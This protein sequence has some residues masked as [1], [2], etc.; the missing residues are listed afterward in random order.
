MGVLLIID[1]LGKLLEYASAH[2]SMSDVYLLQRLAEYAA[3]AHSPFLVMGVLHQ[4]FSGYARDLAQEDRQEWEKVRGRFE[5]IVFEQSAA[6]MLRLIAQAMTVREEYRSG[7]DDSRD[8]FELFCDEAWAV[9]VVPPGLNRA[10]ERGLLSSCYPLHPCVTLLLGPIFKRFGQNERSAF[11]FLTSG[12]PHALTDFVARS[13][14]GVLYNLV[15]LYDYLVS[16]FGDS[17]LRS[18]DG[19]RWAE[20]FNVESQLPDLSQGELSVLRVIALLGIVGRWNGVA[21]TPEVARYALAP[22]MGPADVDEGIRSLSARSAIV[23]RRY[24]NTYNLWEGSDIDVDARIADA[25]ARIAMEASSVELLRSHFSLRPMVAR[26]HSFKSGTLRFFDVVFASPSTLN[27]VAAAFEAAAEDSKADG[28]IIVL[29][30]EARGDPPAASNG[31]VEAV[32]SLPD[33]VLCV[34]GN[35]REVESLARELAALRSARSATTDLQHDAT[36]RREFATRES[37]IWRRLEQAMT[38]I[39]APPRPGSPRTRWYRLGVEQQLDTPRAL[40]ELLS[41]VCNELFA[42]SPVIQNEIINRRELSSSAAAAQGK[43][44]ARMLRDSNK[45]G[46]SIEGYPPERSIY[47]SVLRELN[48]HQEHQGRWSFAASEKSVRADARPVCRAIKRFFHSAKTE[49]RSLDELFT[50]LRQRP[51]GLRDGILP[52]LVCAALIGN[53]A[54]VAVY[55]DGAFAPQLTEALF[56]RLIRDPARYTV[57]QWNVSGVRITVFEKLG[58][59]LGRSVVASRVE[60]RD[61][62]DVVK[63]LVRFVRTLSDFSRQTTSFSPTAVAVREAIAS[64]SEPDHLL[65]LDL[66]RACGVEPFDDSRK[67]RV[68]DVDAFLRTLQ[69]SLTE[70]QRAYDVLLQGLVADIHREL[71]VPEPQQTKARAHI[72]RRSAEI[73]PVALNP[74]IKVFITR[75]AD[76]AADD[77]IWTEQLAAFLARRHPALWHDDDRGRFS[78]RLA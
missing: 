7:R 29:L 19:K 32:A 15:H 45:E 39:M 72:A 9:N 58:L 25:R 46:L 64:A 3:R 44:I 4:D 68:H 31:S 61:L 38:Q 16:A 11:S 59:M 47:L 48:L 23:Y 53:E 6:D 70:I 17:L 12:E 49:P 21:P 20:A 43:L 8:H 54:D 56:E 73:A 22:T 74:D 78:I 71:G 5:D 77:A 13:P 67:E 18:K 24:N 66:P 26:R 27:D 65:F 52:I 62:L 36:A 63:P 10:A 28:Q 75:L 30:P 57:R 51:Y 60:P 34:P 76:T 40:N 69:A 14:K 1:E 37:D 50:Q 2:P 41:D 55:E 33:T 35:A 42:S